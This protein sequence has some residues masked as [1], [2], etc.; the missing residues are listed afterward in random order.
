[1]KWYYELGGKVLTIGSDSHEESH[2]GFKIEEIK[3]E[4]KKIGFEQF[5]TFEQMQPTFHQL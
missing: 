4:L 1:M 3:E 5:C 2:L